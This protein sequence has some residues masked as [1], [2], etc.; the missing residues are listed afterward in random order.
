M[1]C[2]YTCA[3]RY[4]LFFGFILTT[5]ACSLFVSRLSLASAIEDDKDSNVY[6]P[7]DYTTF[8]P[9]ARGGSYT[10]PVF[11]TAIKRVS[12]AIHTKDP[13]GG[14]LTSITT[15][16]SSMTAFNKD[17]TRLLLQHF[18]YFSLYDGAGNFIRDLYP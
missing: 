14:T 9:P 15:E 2:K 12:D 1:I 18:S 8:Q 17:N 11:G 3:F 5:L 16:Y 13:W 10:D 7:P 4:R 6:R